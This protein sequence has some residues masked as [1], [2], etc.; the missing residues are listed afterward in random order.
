MVRYAKEKDIPRIAEI[1]VFGKRTA[2]RP[3]FNDDRVSFNEIQVVGLAKEYQEFPDRIARMLV[4]DD[5][6]IRGVINYLDY[7]EEIELCDFYVDPFFKGNGYGRE[8]IRFLMEEAGRKGKKKIFL[9]VIK[10]NLSAR[11]FY[12]RNGF[13]TDGQERLI[14]GTDVLDLRY[15]TEIAKPVRR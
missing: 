8:L 9:W 12:E 10:E 13:R 4:Y 11:R 14:E 1:L 2:Y 3:I 5:G 6:I 15:E 7:G